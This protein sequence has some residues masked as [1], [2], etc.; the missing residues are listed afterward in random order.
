MA[1]QASIFNQE[2][3]EEDQTTATPEVENKDTEPKENPYVDMLQLIVDDEG[4]PKYSSVE[5]GLKA[6]AHAQQHISKLEQENASFRQKVENTDTVNDLLKAKESAKDTVSPEKISELVEKALANV[7]SKRVQK[8]NANEVSSLLKSEFGEE[9]EEKYV[10][11]AAAAGLTV[12]QMDSLVFNSPT[13]AK[14]LLGLDDK[15]SKAVSKSTST[16]NTEANVRQPS[17]EQSP[18]TVMFAATQNEL[19]NAWRSAAPKQD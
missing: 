1:D 18:K 9:A 11:K 19:I 17:Q 14:R 6:L 12:E 3:Q 13:A 5:D 8:A 4:K 15:P 2:P 16:I 7:E 10:E